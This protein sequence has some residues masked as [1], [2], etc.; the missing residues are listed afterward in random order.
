MPSKK[1]KLLLNC[2]NNTRQRTLDHKSEIKNRRRRFAI[3][4]TFLSELGGFKLKHNPK[5]FHRGVSVGR[6][7]FA[8]Q[9]IPRDTKLFTVNTSNAKLRKR[10]KKWRHYQIEIDDDYVW[11]PKQSSTKQCSNAAFLLNTA[12]PVLMKDGKFDEDATF[13]R[14]NVKFSIN[15]RVK[16]ATVTLITTKRIPRGQELL[17][18]YGSHYRLAC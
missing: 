3:K 13:A 2:D 17:V 1:N 6:A 18:Y 7:I 5:H 15:R 16:P 8:N 12:K 10:S 14:C 9:V 4:R 11:V